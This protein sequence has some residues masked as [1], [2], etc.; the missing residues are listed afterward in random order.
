VSRNLAA[1]DATITVA[2]GGALA[3]AVDRLLTDPEERQHR[4]A[5]AAAVALRETGVLDA[6]LERLAPLLDRLS[7]RAPSSSMVGVA[8]PSDAAPDPARACA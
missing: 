6:V 3:G 7:A 4:A 8:T 1:A 5:A 2:D